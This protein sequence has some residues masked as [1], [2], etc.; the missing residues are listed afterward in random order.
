MVKVLTLNTRGI[1]GEE[2]QINLALYSKRQRA[3]ILLLQVNRSM[4]LHADFL[5]ALFFNSEGGDNI[6][7]QNV[8]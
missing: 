5:H 7:L 6:F 3:D 2:K 8:G 4:K 1:K